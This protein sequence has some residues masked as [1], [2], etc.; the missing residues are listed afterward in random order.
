MILRGAPAAEGLPEAS[1]DYSQVNVR[2]GGSQ[3]GQLPSLV[4]YSLQRL[5]ADNQG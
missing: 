5:A 4:G 1:L 3:V 2:A